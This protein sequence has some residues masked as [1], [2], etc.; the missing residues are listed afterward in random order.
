MSNFIFGSCFTQVAICRLCFG[1]MLAG[2]N[3]A[4]H[5]VQVDEDFFTSKFDLLMIQSPHSNTDLPSYRLSAGFVLPRSADIE[6]AGPGLSGTSQWRPLVA[7][8]EETIFA[9]LMRV[10][11]KGENLKMTLRPHSFWI[12]WHKELR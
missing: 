11:L 6:P 7:L 10:E 12:R 9:S 1:L 5:A 4:A 8:K 2:L 3:F